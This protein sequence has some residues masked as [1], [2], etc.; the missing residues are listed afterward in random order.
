MGSIMQLDDRIG[1]RLK[2]Q[3]LHVF[4]TV[5]QAGSMGKAAQRLNS[6][7]P[8]VSRS[9]AELEHIAD[10]AGG[11]VRIGSSPALA[12][13]FVSAVLDRLSVLY[14]RIVFHVLATQWEGL[15]H[16]LNERKVDFLV[17]PRF[18]PF[19]DDKL[20]FEAV[21]DDSYVVV[22]GERNPWVGRRRIDLSELLN[23]PWALPPPDTVLGSIAF[24]A[25]EGRGLARPRTTVFSAPGEVRM[26]L[27]TTGRFLTICPTSVLKFPTRRE[28]IKVLPV[29][30]PIADIP[31]GIVTLKGRTLSPGAQLLIDCA[32]QIAKPLTKK[33]R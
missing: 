3:D 22:A 11:E 28:G 5:A 27:L 20:D 30:L 23:E 6:T 18:G 15:H 13:S 16:A 24:D 25:F 21:Y 19:A 7:Q 1:R 14:P 29:E 32:R 9:I 2:L 33:R 8:A 31:T 4:M 10:P 12:A 26:S 17:A